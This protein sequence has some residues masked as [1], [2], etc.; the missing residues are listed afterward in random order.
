MTDID[1]DELK[2]QELKT[3]SSVSYAKLVHELYQGHLPVIVPTEK[4]TFWAIFDPHE[5]SRLYTDTQVE[6]E[7][8]ITRI[9]IQ[10]NLAA[11][12]LLS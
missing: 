3:V 1:P 12:Q 4:G 7:E 2:K 6:R 11:C 8:H 5:E 10:V 9:I